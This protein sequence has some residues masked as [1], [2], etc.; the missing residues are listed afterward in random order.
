MITRIQ[1]LFYKGLKYIDISLRPFSILIGPN[2]SGKSSLL[3]VFVLLQDILNDGPVAAIEKRSSSFEELTWNRKENYFE[4]A[5]EFKIPPGKT[6]TYKFAR[7]EITIARRDGAGIVIEN[8]N[9]WLLKAQNGNKNGSKQLA[10]FPREIEAPRHIAQKG[11][12][13]PAGWKKIISKS[14][15][16]NDYFNSEVT[17]WRITY[18]FGPQKSSLARI[19]EDPTKFPVALWVR[20]VLMEGIQFLQLNSLEMKWPCRPDASL[21]FEPS[22][23]NLPKILKNLKNVQPENFQRW[24]EH[25]QTALPDIADI[26]IKE[27]QEDRF[28]YIQAKYK[29]GIII[30]SWLLSDGTL[31]L[32]A[33]TAIA[34][35]SVKDKLFIIEEPENGLHP[36]AIETAIQSLSSTY[37]NQ[38]L[39]ATHSPIVLRLADLEDLL[40]FSKTASGSVDVVNGKNHPKLANWKNEVDLATLHAAG[41]LQ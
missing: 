17:R 29:N 1:I 26:D 24:I 8:E 20:N 23:R 13:A 15:Q 2:A 38:I 28:L 25:V 41:V 39:L 9:L 7:Y 18:R 16:G 5:V 11:G 12:R 35:I 37:E 21:T 4:I 40:C 27:R 22:G 3:D 10:L 34:Y 30:P 31:R 14:N 32:L 36:L 33:Q 6:K 19:P